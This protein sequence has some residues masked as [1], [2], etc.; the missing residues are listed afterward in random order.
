MTRCLRVL[1][2]AMLCVTMFAD[3]C[4]QCSEKIQST[5]VYCPRCGHNLAD[6]RFQSL[7]NTHPR[8]FDSEPVDLK[9]VG[10]QNRQTDGG[11]VTP[12]ELSLIGPV[13]VPGGL[14]DSVTGLQLSLIYGDSEI[15]KG[16]QVGLFQYDA[17]MY[18]LQLGFWN[19]TA[20]GR[21]I[22]VGAF[23]K[24]ANLCGAQFGLVNI[25]E[26]TSF[27]FQFGLLNFIMDNQ[28]P[29]LPIFNC[30]Y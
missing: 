21:G 30:Y 13:G 14:C 1:P 7:Q 16:I 8:P 15:M 29:V 9:P 25:A 27:G 11:I 19:Q 6:W 28:V 2:F 10:Q 24:M 20:M 5:D 4:P 3:T 26:S 23:N 17:E 22:Q 18:G 12:F